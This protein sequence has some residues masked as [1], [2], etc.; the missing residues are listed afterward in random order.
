VKI[1][2]INQYYPPDGTNSAHVLGELAEDLARKHQVGVIAGAPSYNVGPSIFESAV[3]VTRVRSA[4]M[5][6]ETFLGRGVDYV[7]FLFLATVVA[8]RAPRPDVI[9]VM[10]NPPFLGLIGLLAGIRH[11]RPFVQLS[12]DIYPDIAVALGVL[13]RPRIVRGWR[14][15]NRLVRRHASRIVVVG[16]DMAEKLE[17]EG[18]PAD[19]LVFIPTWASEPGPSIG[20]GES[21]RSELGWAGKFVV[22]H[23][24]NMGLAQNLGVLVRAAVQMAETDPGVLV[25]LL[26]DGAARARVERLVAEEGLSNVLLLDHRPKEE[27]RALMAAADLHVVSLVPGLWGCAAPSKT[28]DIMALGKPFVAAVDAGSE[29]ARI[30]GELDCG[31]WVPADDAVALADAIL[32]LKSRPLDGV[33]ARARAGYEARYERSLSTGATLEVLEAAAASN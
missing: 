5:G 1:L 32:E 27:A 11:R 14:W 31:A 4:A 16:R 23:A 33:G 29:P 12:H 10:T 20:D 17:L 8:L 6:R 28:Y 19:K 21:L 2:V 15:L 7:S 22:M 3:S 9:V 24:G 13:R 26:G 30:V 18:V 25:V